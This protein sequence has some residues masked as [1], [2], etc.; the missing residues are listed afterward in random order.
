MMLKGLFNIIYLWAAQRSPAMGCGDSARGLAK[1]HPEA[2]WKWLF[3]VLDLLH[4]PLAMC[5]R[6]AVLETGL[7]V[8]REIRVH[9]GDSERQHCNAHFTGL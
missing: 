3:R 5:T 7:E 9:S 2:S 4:W 6:R 8:F 1:A